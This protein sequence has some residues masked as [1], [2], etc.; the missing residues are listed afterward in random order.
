MQ[1]VNKIILI[2]STN[3]LVLRLKRLH[4]T[5][6]SR[7]CL[8]HSWYFFGLIIIFWRVIATSSGINNFQITRIYLLALKFTVDLEY[9]FE[10]PLHHRILTCSHVV[11][12]HQRILILVKNRFVFQSFI[13]L[14]FEKVQVNLFAMPFNFISNRRR[15]R[16][17]FLIGSSFKRFLVKCFEIHLLIDILTFIA[18]TNSFL[19]FF[20]FWNCWHYVK[21][22]PHLWSSSSTTLSNRRFTIFGVEI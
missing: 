5:S 16:F 6:R 4:L 2:K 1:P 22:F 7:F 11:L 12:S 10:K 13:V 20:K 21:H 9:W 3:L 8:R 19:W 17:T 14:S 18:L 15:N